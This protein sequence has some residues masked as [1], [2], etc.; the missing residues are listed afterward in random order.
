MVEYIAANNPGDDTNFLAENLIDQIVKNRKLFVPQAPK[1]EVPVVIDTEP[2]DIVP[3]FDLYDDT[4]SFDIG[5][6]KKYKIKRIITVIEGYLKKERIVFGKKLT[7][8]FATSTF[9]DRFISCINFFNIAKSSYY[10]NNGRINVE[11]PEENIL[12]F[13]DLC[14]ET[15]VLTKDGRKYKA[16]SVAGEMLR[17]GENNQ[18]SMK[19]EDMLNYY[20]REQTDHNGR[21]ALEVYAENKFYE[22]L[23][24][25]SVGVVVGKLWFGTGHEQSIY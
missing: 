9:T 13:Y 7:I 17:L 14:S 19:D 25:L 3:I 10:N 21:S 1:E 24:D 20:L 18:S 15:E 22:L 16:E 2:V 8:D 23:G 11:Y 12:F 4:L 5:R 6:Q